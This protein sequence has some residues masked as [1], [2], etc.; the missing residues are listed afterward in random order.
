MFIV[1][2]T[3]KSNPAMV[4]VARENATMFGTTYEQAAKI[5][6][7]HAKNYRSSVVIK[8]TTSECGFVHATA[9]GTKG[10]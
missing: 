10:W 3:T 9:T 1:Y 4:E 6:T 8:V 7:T 5:A 2:V